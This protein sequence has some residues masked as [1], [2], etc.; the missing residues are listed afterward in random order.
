MLATMAATT[1]PPGRTTILTGEDVDAWLRPR[2]VAALHGVGPATAAKLNQYGLHTIGDLADAP[3]PA[4]TRTL[5]ATNGRALHAHAHGQ[6]FRTLAHVQLVLV[7]ETQA[8]ALQ[9]G[10]R[11]TRAQAAIALPIRVVL[12]GGQEVVAALWSRRQLR[13]GWRYEVTLPVW[14]NGPGDAVEPAEYR[15]WVRAPDHVRPVDGVSYDDVP[16]EY[17]EPPSFLERELGPRRPSGWVLAKVGG[18]GPSRASFT[19]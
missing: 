15:V 11:E 14:K 5:G 1:T 6:D 18:R 2:P 3:L 9:L 8:M 16:N 12:P 4:L 19:P 7:A 17:L 13:D 10:V